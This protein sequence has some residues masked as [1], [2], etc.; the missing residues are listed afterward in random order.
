M[1]NSAIADHFTLLSKLMDIH[2]ANSFKSKTY[3]I[4]A[5]YIERLE[6]Q[7]ATTDRREYSSIKGLG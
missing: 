5:F 1:N 4:A 6:E 3:S 2:G 7:L